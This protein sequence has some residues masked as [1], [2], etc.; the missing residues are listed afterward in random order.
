VADRFHVIRLINRHLLALWRE[1]D[2][3]GS[4]NRGL[5]SVMRLH[6]KNHKADQQVRLQSYLRA[7]PVLATTY[8]F[9]QRLCP[10]L[11]KKHRTRKQCIPLVRL[12]LRSIGYLRNR[13]LTQMITLAQP[14]QLMPL[15]Q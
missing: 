9:K 10:L 1:L 13:G 15:S 4:R 2:P 11:L 14:S 12:L 7:H 8:G 3:V 6:R 5:I